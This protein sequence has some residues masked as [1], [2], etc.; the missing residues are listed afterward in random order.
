[1]KLWFNRDDAGYALLN[2]RMPQTSR[3]SR[4]SIEDNF[5]VKRGNPTDLD[6]PPGGKSLMVRYRNG[7]A[8]CV[9]FRDIEDT[10]SLQHRYA[11]P[12]EGLEVPF[13]VVEAALKIPALSV[14]FTSQQTTIGTNQIVGGLISHCGVGLSLG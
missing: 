13:T 6:S 5:W 2:L 14:S 3:S 11:N 12:P 8:V 1:L 4:V 10:E 9:M 7:D